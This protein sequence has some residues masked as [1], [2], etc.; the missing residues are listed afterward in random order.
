VEGGAS[1]GDLLGVDV[2]P[3][4]E[5]KLERVNLAALGRV[6]DGCTPLSVLGVDI[7]RDARLCREE[8]GH[9]VALA[10]HESAN[11]R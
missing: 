8:V 1:G 4:L 2:G 5:Q 7:E 9:D 11:Q 3:I 10:M 6:V